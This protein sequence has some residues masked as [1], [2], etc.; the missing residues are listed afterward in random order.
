MK[1]NQK[2]PKEK[3]GGSLAKRKLCKGGREH[4]WVEVLPWGVEAIEGVYNGDPE[5][6]YLGELAIKEFE[7]KIYEDLRSIGIEVGY[8]RSVISDLKN[9]SRHY[10]CSVCGKKDY[11]KN[12]KFN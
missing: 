6:Y 4:D 2:Q 8:Y 5:P 11:T 9:D 7:N 3:D 12:K 1:H 10:I